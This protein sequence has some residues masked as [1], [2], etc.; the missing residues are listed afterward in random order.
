M[1]PGRLPPAFA[2]LEP[3]VERWALTSRT[4]RVQRRIQS[5]PAE[6]EEFY[7]AARDLLV[8]A[9][10]YLDA[11][12]PDRLEGPGK[13]LLSLILALPQIALATEQ[14]GDVEPTHARV[15]ARFIIERT[16]ED[17]GRSGP[18]PSATC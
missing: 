10:R 18:T 6:R 4:E 16:S 1:N 9:L 2:A 17:F 11:Q 7:K 12:D 13:L 5:Q 15:Q 8:P 3:F 14:Q